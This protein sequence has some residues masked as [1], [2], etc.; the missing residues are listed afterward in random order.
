MQIGF[1]RPESIKALPGVFVPILATA[2][3]DRQNPPVP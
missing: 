1:P 2:T 3:G